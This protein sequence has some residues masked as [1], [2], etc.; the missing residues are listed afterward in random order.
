MLRFCET[1]KIASKVKIVKISNICGHKN[2]KFS[3]QDERIVL[4]QRYQWVLSSKTIWNQKNGD[5]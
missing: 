4:N 5:K 3:M 1:E 2:K